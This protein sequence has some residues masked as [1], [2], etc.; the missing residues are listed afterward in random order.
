[1]VGNVS[2]ASG[3][4]LVKYATYACGSNMMTTNHFMHAMRSHVDA[5]FH[6]GWIGTLGGRGFVG[7]GGGATPGHTKTHKGVC[8]N[9]SGGSK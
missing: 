6:D 8:L 7:G 5:A 9:T 2:L 3:L 1:V 4:W